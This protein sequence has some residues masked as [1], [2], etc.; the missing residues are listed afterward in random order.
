MHQTERIKELNGLFLQKSFLVNYTNVSAYF[1]QQF[2]LP[3]YAERT[4]SRD[5]KALKELLQVRYPVLHDSTGELIKYARSQ[6]QFYFIRDDISA[7]PSISEK[8]LSQIASTIEMNKHLFSG[9]AGEGIV[10]KLRAIALENELAQQ[11]EMLPWSAIQLV[12]DGARSGEKLF[13]E[14]LTSIYGQH[15]VEFTHQG[16]SK[17]SQVKKITGVPLLLKEYNNGWYTGWYVLFQPATPDESVI[18]MDLSHLR[19]FALDRISDIR[20]VKKETNLRRADHFNPADYFKNTLGIFRS[21]SQQAETLRISINKASWMFNYL[22]KYPIHASQ[23][24]IEENEEQNIFQYKLEIEQELENFLI[25]Y[26]AE[27]TILAPQKLKQVIQD[28]LQET[29]KK[30]A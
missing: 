13:Q 10:N 18:R 4:F 5:L 6:N 22:L 11:H 3:N 8:E 15:I 25:R 28:Q 20:I 19:V 27:M 23:Q 17:K 14:L 24:L 16:L 26:A 30:H 7:F 9:G 29:L 12:N 1:Q 21:E 2:D